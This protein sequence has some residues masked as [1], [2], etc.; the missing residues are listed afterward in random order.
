[1]SRLPHPPRLYNS[2]YTWR[3][4]QI[5]KLLVMQFSP[6]SHQFAPNILLNTLFSNT[7]SL[8]SFLNIREQVSR[9]YRT[10]GKIIFL[11]ILDKSSAQNKVQRL[12]PY[13]FHFVNFSRKNS[14]RNPCWPSN[15]QSFLSQISLRHSAITCST[16]LLTAEVTLT[17]LQFETS[18]QS[19]PL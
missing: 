1:M 16:C 4:V 9:P 19:P 11:C 3:R 18:E 8:C 6:L 5:M 14:S 13:P 12:T 17:G 2:N 7:P 10:T 15:I